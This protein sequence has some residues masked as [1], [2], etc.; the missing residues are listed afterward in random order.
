V[1]RK[2]ETVSGLTGPHEPENRKKQKRRIYMEKQDRI[3]QWIDCCH[4]IKVLHNAGIETMTQLSEMSSE[5]ILQLRG[6]GRVIAGD[7]QKKLEA[8]RENSDHLSCK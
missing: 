1:R 4:T 8:Y 2:I 3:E 6:I 5:Q 7:L